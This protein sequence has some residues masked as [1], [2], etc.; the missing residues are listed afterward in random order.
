MATITG[1]LGISSALELDTVFVDLVPIFLIPENI[2]TNF[3]VISGSLPNSLN[4][5]EIFST[6]AIYGILT[7]MDDYVP[8]FAKPVNF[9]Y[10]GSSKAGQNYAGYG[11]GLAQGKSFGFTVR[12]NLSELYED[13]LYKD[14]SFELYVKTNYSTQRD[15]YLREYYINTPIVYNG[16][17]YNIEDY[18]TLMKTLGYFS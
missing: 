13:K 5:T 6:W 7:D 15:K 17:S 2:I 12:C 14:I 11:A 4:I 8:E 1:D 3:T 16:I 18:I 10:D 9:S